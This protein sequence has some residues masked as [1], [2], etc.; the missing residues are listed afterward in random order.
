MVT[1][2][3]MDNKEIKEKISKYANF[4]PVIT[5]NDKEKG[6]TFKFFTPNEIALWRAESLYTK[7]PI[8]INWIKKFK[9]NKVFFDIGANVGMYTVFAS[10]YSEVKVYSFEP[11][12]NNYQIL[13]QNIYLNNLSKQVTAYPF[14]ISNINSITKLNLSK[15]IKGG[16]HSTVGEK[17]DH[18]LKEFNPVFEQGTLSITL[19]EL[20]NKYQL[21]VPNYLKIDVDGIEYKI[22]ESSQDTLKNKKL[23]SVLIEI[24]AQRKED[25]K[26]IE[27][28]EKKGFK[29]NKEQVKSAT[30]KTGAHK[31][32]AEY[33][34]YR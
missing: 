16:S 10:I 24:N 21:P 34:F 20:I 23:E 30:R 8:T 15:W 7:E 9:K 28:L 14:G 31:G 25:G 19:D 3:L 22:I 18:N 33:L 4:I 2:I 11:E 32:Y 29:Y 5:L 13:N 6:K 17:L 26:I 27:T 1:K 12:S